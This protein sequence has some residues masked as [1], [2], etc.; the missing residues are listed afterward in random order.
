MDNKAKILAKVRKCMA[1]ASS[2][3]EHEAAAALRQA[4]K[5]MDKYGLSEEHVELSELGLEQIES[6][7]VN[8]P[9]WAQALLTIIGRAFQCTVFSGYRT[10][11]FV[12]RAENAHIA[13]FTALVLMRQIKQAR[14]RFL[15]E[16]VSNMYTPAQKRKIS[17][18]Y[19]EGWVSAVQATVLEF[20]APLREEDDRKHTRFMQEIHNKKVTEARQPKSAT[21]GNKLAAIAAAAGARDGDGVQLHTP[22]N[23]SAPIPGISFQSQ[24]A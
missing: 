21:R 19:C 17:Q 18:G 5:M 11:S 13:G 8:K 1:L 22:V 4:R 3:N 6:E 12:G 10:T 23:G 15:E 16:R 7:H 24:P 14:K 2:A 9:L 20:A